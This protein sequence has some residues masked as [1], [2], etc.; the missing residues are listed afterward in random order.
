MKS[1]TFPFPCLR[2]ENKAFPATRIPPLTWNP[3]PFLALREEDR[4]F[5]GE[6]QGVVALF[7][8]LSR[9]AFLSLTRSVPTPA[10]HLSPGWSMA[11]WAASPC[12]VRRWGSRDVQ[13]AEGQLKTAHSFVPPLLHTHWCPPSPP[14]PAQQAPWPSLPSSLIWPCRHP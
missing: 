10:P 3:K 12:C 11:G 6:R 2:Q 8:S 14:T 13:G 5:E 7:W 9:F 1:D 4:L